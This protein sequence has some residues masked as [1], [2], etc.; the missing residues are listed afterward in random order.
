MNVIMTVHSKPTHLRTYDYANFSQC[1]VKNLILEVCPSI[2][3]TP[4]YIQFL[5]P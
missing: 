2:L 3:D 5:E 4:V 1:D